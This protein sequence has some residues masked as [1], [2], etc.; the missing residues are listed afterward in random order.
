M[1]ARTL[2]R[3]AI[4]RTLRAHGPMSRRVLAHTA[5]LPTGTVVAALEELQGEH[6][7]EVVFTD[8][9]TGGRPLQHWGLARDAGTALGVTF[10]RFGLTLAAVDF[11]GEVRAVDERPMPSPPMPVPVARALAQAVE[12]MW[13][14]L[15]TPVG[16][17]LG[18]GIALPGIYA[19]DR[20][21]LFL[22]NLSGWVGS[23]PRSLLADAI[24][25]P[26]HIENDA[27]A[28]A[29]AEGLRGSARGVRN[30]VY[31]L[32]ADGTGGA[33][34]VDGRLVRGA[35][36]VAG[37][38]GHLPAGGRHVCN[39]GLT[40]CLET[41]ASGLALRRLVE[42]EGVAPDAAIAHLAGHLGVALAGVVNA[43]APETVV[44]GGWVVD[45]HP[46]LLF[47]VA[48]SARA[49]IV[50]LLSTHV[51]WA[52]AAVA[53]APAVGAALMVLDG[54]G[55][56]GGENERASKALRGT[57]APESPASP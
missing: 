12:A 53:A 28:A 56:K 49:H 25:L 19:P 54:A 55:A 21:V 39:C 2:E 18:V 26:V 11:A 27:N 34:V 15:Q 5:Q 20:G 32:V 10:G 7:V 38:F 37:E 30:Y 14:R 51:R 50:P 3:H 33:V 35:I 44:L 36:G 46:E 22:P 43:L 16:Q 6:L 48:E 57:L 29:Y 45:R 9:S 23:D 47:A 13:E 1:P 52:P 8:R 17:R 41:E 42:D 4:L 24:G 40:G 31:C